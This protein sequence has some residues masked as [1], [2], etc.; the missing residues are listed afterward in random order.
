MRCSLM[1]RITVCSRARRERAMPPAAFPS[2]RSNYPPE[3]STHIFRRWA[4]PDR[5]ARP[6]MD[7]TR[8]RS[9]QYKGSTSCECRVPSTERALVSR[10][11]RARGL[12]LLYLRRKLIMRYRNRSATLARI[13]SPHHE[14][15]FRK[16][17]DQLTDV[18]VS[19]LLWI[20]DRFAKLRVSETLPDHGHSR[21]RQAPARRSRRKMCAVKI[22]ILM[23]GA[24]FY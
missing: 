16:V 13:P 7:L 1:I 6:A 8:T 4:S 11:G 9:T 21:R 12:P 5:V 22:M 2:R 18:P 20:F 10:A 14:L 15:V 23:A 24:A 17:L 19:I 3:I